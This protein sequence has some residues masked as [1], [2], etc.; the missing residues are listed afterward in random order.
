MNNTFN[1]NGVVVF[2]AFRDLVGVITRNVIGT[3]NTTGLIAGVIV[4]NL[5]DVVLGGIV[6]SNFFSNF[7][8]ELFSLGG[9]TA[10]ISGSVIGW[11]LSITFWYIQLLIWDLVLRDGK[12]DL[13]SDL[14]PIV[15]GCVVAI[16]DTLID[17]SIVI[18][19]SSQSTFLR[20]IF[21][22]GYDLHEA[23]TNIAVILVFIVTGLNELLNKMFLSSLMPRY[24]GYK[25]PQQTQPPFQQR[26][27]PDPGMFS[28][29]P[30]G[31]QKRQNRVNQSKK[32][33]NTP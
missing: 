16:L 11:M 33:A 15:A 21:Y 17:T 28:P 5:L 1:S 6:L 19:I 3:V 9:S 27:I 20:G 23:V 18:P 25:P 10:R 12:I 2:S 13:K 32:K 7:Q 29:N 8:A 14:V 31:S 30:V 24:G 26:P 22:Q 4:I